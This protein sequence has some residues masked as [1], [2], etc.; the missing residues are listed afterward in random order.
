MHSACPLVRSLA[1]TTLPREGIRLDSCPYIGT[2]DTRG[3]LPCR[4]IKHRIFVI[5]II[6]LAINKRQNMDTNV[7]IFGYVH[8]VT[9]ITVCLRTIC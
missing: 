5:I 9:D 1:Y 3:F 2:H 4:I 8:I 7:A 6:I